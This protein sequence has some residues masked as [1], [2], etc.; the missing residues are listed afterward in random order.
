MIIEEQM[1]LSLLLTCLN[2]FFESLQAVSTLNFVLN[3]LQSLA[4]YP[5]RPPVQ[6]VLV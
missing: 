1:W 3:M 6:R 5:L 2:V 4:P